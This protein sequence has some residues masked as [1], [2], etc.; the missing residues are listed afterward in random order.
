MTEPYARTKEQREG[1]FARANE[2]ETM[3]ATAIS[4]VPIHLV[5]NT[6]A[7]DLLDFEVPGFRLEVKE[8]RQPLTG[9]WTQTSLVPEEHLF[10]LDELTL[11]KALLFGDAWFLLRNV[12][13]GGTLHL[14]SAVTVGCV[15]RTRLNRNGKGK[16]L[17]DLRNFREVHALETIPGIIAWERNELLHSEC[18]GALETDEV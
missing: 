3:V 17:F 7:T 16:L 4:H 6:K 10:V 2:F 8:K 12:P 1:D 13:A 18:C 5:S 15:E 14:A 9:R 11:R